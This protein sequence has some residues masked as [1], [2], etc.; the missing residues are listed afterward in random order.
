MAGAKVAVVEVVG[1]E[2]A[3]AKVGGTAMAETEVAEITGKCIDITIA[4]SLIIC[5]IEGQ[6]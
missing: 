6:K 4:N 1:A 2:V 3:G 5:F